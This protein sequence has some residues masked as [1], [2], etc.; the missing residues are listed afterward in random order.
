[1]PALLPNQPEGDR[2]DPDGGAGVA[3][4]N[5]CAA[6]LPESLGIAS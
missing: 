1:M 5:D 2:G 3:T 4:I 6:D